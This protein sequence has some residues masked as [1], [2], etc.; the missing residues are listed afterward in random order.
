MKKSLIALAVLAASGAAM[1]QSSVTLYGIADL[2][3]VKAKGSS[4]ALAS[5]GVSTS[6]WGLK[7]SEDLGGGLAANFNFEQGVDLTNG[8][9]KGNGFDR[10][11]WLGLSGGFGEI[12]LGKMWNAYDDIVGA[13]S[14]LFDSGALTTNNLAPS[15]ALE[16]GNPGNAVYYATPSFG[17]VSG[18]VST[19]FK[20]GETNARVTAFHVK[21][22]GGPLF[23]GL[24]HEQQK[25][26]L[27][28]DLKLTRLSASYDFGAAKLL[29]SVGQ[30]KDVA[31][32]VTIGVDV[33]L[34][35]ALTLSAGATQVR[36]EVGDNGTRYG[37]A[38][39]YGLS[40][41]TT[42]YTGF[43]KDNKA[44]GDGHLFAV[45]LKHAF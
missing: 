25:D 11:A 16:A 41:R 35:S 20:T 22:E 30:V 7:G 5:G 14:P 45:G 4:A 28:A 19:T 13:T 1:A 8:S 37:L 15:Y 18:A 23:V 39:A 34:S 38:A 40:K 21:Y 33:P 31:D 42:A 44:A 6:R 17:G 9:L 36:P 27:S 12:K 2:A 32:D 29:A 3:V 10:Q 43:Y 26:D 24:A